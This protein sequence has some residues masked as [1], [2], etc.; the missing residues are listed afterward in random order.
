M[1]SEPLP[2]PIVFTARSCSYGSVS[3][4]LQVP[5]NQMLFQVL[6]YKSPILI[7][8]KYL[9]I[10]SYRP[11]GLWHKL[12]RDPPGEEARILYLFFSSL[13]VGNS[14]NKKDLTLQ[15]RLGTAITRKKH[16]WGFW[17]LGF[18]DK[19]HVHGQQ[20]LAILYCCQDYYIWAWRPIRQWRDS[21][22]EPQT[23]SF[24]LQGPPR[25]NRKLKKAI[26]H[27]TNPSL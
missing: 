6:R 7:K 23:S 8:S 26:E 5:N 25:R 13:G 15:A 17:S 14:T 11:L 16:R 21:H 3:S 9:L 12:C 24:S 2:K 19:E 4:R 27:H 20:A 1:N 18:R 22:V 10:R